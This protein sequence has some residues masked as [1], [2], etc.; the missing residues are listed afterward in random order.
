MARLFVSDV[1]LDASEPRAIEQFLGFLERHAARAEAL[2]ILGDLFE[3][4]V[5]DDDASADKRLV[6]AALHTL[7]ARGVACFVLHGNRDFLLG[8]EFCERTGCRL[9]TDPI[10]A[11]FDGERVLL[12]H[13]DALCT[14]DHPYQELRSIVRTPQW[15]RRFLALPL[16]DRELLADQARAGSRQHTSRTIPYI[17]DVNDGAVAAAFRATGV[18]RIIHGHTHRPG[19]HEMLIDGEPARRIVLGAWYEQG[20]YLLYE[21]GRYELL[22]L[23]R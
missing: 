10:V 11:E 6:G 3:T 5:G 4:W 17:M 20:S 23:P 15:Q 22:E 14:D 16:A 9:L 8:R 13:G 2:Y 21:S 18:R 19:I 1:H 7:T 12:T